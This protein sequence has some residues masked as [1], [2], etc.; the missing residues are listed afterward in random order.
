MPHRITNTTNIIGEN[1][2]FEGTI[3]LN[4]ALR[5]DGTFKGKKLSMEHLV[6]GKTG[7]ITSDLEVESTVIEGTILGNIF[8]SIRAMLLPTAHIL[9]D[10]TTPELIIQKG[11]IWDGHC[12]ISTSPDV[13]IAELVNKSLDDSSK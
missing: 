4:G 7:R 1:S 9:G 8:A 2:T 5:I 10:I 11:V 3:K 6:I 13:N 12:R